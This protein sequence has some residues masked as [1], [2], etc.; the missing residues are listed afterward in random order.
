MSSWG[1]TDGGPAVV[2]IQE[3]NGGVRRAVEG[4]SWLVAG[5]ALVGAQSAWEEGCTR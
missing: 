2:G 1:G 4:Q 5:M 3:V